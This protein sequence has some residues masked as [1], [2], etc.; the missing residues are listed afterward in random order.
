MGSV[1]RESGSAERGHVAPVCVLAGHL[2]AKD[3]KV[4]V[5][6]IGSQLAADLH[7]GAR[8][9]ETRARNSLNMPH[10]SNFD[11][12]VLQFREEGFNIFN[13]TQWSTINNY[14]GYAEFPL[15]P[16]ERT[17]RGGCSL[18]FVLHFDGFLGEAD[19]GWEGTGKEGLMI[20]AV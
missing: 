13:H 4:K 10:R 6:I 11:M 18:H 1:A 9:S 2:M 17:C 20:G 14:V 5:G 12:S 8:P 16:P 19:L 15:L 7:A 3:G